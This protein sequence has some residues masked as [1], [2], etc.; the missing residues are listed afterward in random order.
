MANL[1]GDKPSMRTTTLPGEMPIEI[2]QLPDDPE[3]ARARIKL[4]I[5]GPWN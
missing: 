4:A 3:L 2:G 1:P 5:G